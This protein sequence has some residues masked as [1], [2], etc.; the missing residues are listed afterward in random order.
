MPRP[1]ANM[2]LL[3]VI[4]EEGC[5]HLVLVTQEQRILFFILR[6][7][8]C[9]YPQIIMVLEFHGLQIRLLSGSVG[10]L[11]RDF[12]VS[13]ERDSMVHSVCR[14]L[15]LPVTELCGPVCLC[16]HLLIVPVGQG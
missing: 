15:L 5:S 8:G 12:G 16:T 7:P 10:W 14:C 13:P 6:V 9:S 11:A 4:S 1:I 3:D 2:A